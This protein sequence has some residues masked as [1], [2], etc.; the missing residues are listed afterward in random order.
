MGCFDNRKYVI[1]SSGDAESLVDFSQVMETSFNT[2]R[3]NVAGTQTFVKYEG[4]IPPSVSGC[5][6]KSQAY[7]HHEILDILSGVDWTP[8]GEFV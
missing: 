7:C 4:D 1:I 3:F 2:L 8:S 6:S 5:P